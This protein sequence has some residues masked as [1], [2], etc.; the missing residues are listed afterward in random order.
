[1]GSVK[2]VN[3]TGGACSSQPT[4]ETLFIL[5]THA[6]QGSFANLLVAIAPSVRIASTPTVASL[7][8]PLAFYRS[9]DAVRTGPSPTSPRPQ[10]ASARSRS[11]SRSKDADWST[12]A[13]TVTMKS[14]DG[15]KPGPDSA[16]LP[17]R[18]L[19]KSLDQSQRSK[20]ILLVS[21][22]GGLSPSTAE[23]TGVLVQQPTAQLYHVSVTP[24]FPYKVCAGQQES[25][26]VCI[27]S[28][29]N[30]GAITFRAIRRP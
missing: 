23:T 10:A 6:P 8:G 13:S 30:D 24:D 1:M 27:S 3:G 9:D 28:R 14:T 29:G 26:S 20:Y 18:R 22:Q 2:E 5:L 16:A 17:A 21:D 19:S 15:G 4:A 11:Q 25:G 7:L 12:S